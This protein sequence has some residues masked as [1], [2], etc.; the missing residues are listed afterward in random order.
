MKHHFENHD[1][2][3]E[4]RARMIDLTQ[5]GPRLLASHYLRDRDHG[6]FIQ[7]IGE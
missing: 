7:V 2:V 1:L 4:A 6:R 5:E 3:T